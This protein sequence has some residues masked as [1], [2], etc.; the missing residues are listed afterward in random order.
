MTLKI[1]ASLLLVA[2]VG[3]GGIHRG[4]TGTGTADV[5]RTLKQHAMET[6]DNA[7][8][9]W[10][11]I[12]MDGQTAILT[13]TAQD[14]AAAQEAAQ[15]VREAVWAG[16]LVAGGITQVDTS[17]V[18][19]VAMRDADLP[20]AAPFTWSARLGED[21]TILLDGFVPND[22]I[23]LALAA[24]AANLFPAGVRDEMQ[25]ARGQPEGDWMRAASLGLVALSQLDYGMINAMDGAFTLAGSTAS[26]DAQAQARLTLENMPAAFETTE[27][28]L[29]TSDNPD[30]GPADPDNRDAG[31]QEQQ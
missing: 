17:R 4:L 21:G 12:I 7:G 31:E 23:R 24:E 6:L 13:G 27:S 25:P 16:G 22:R 1:L 18:R 8:I 30:R 19:F 29:V 15:L 2:I 14:S 5:E 28:I 26:Q 11:G 9:D 3:Y 10:A 20:V